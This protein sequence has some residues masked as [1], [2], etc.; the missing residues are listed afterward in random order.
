MI[1]VLLIHII[2]YMNTTQNQINYKKSQIDSMDFIKKNNKINNEEEYYSNKNNK[3][4]SIV[5]ESIK[6]NYENQNN[7]KNKTQK[8]IKIK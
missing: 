3:H 8:I 7:I 4:N 5:N 1:I 2:I 6:G